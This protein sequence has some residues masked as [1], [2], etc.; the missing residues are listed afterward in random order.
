MTTT[1]TTFDPGTHARTSDPHTSHKAAR[2]AAGTAQAHCDTIA[3]K[4]EEHPLVGL[5]ASEIAEHTT[6]DKVQ[7]GR[8]ISDLI[9]QGRAHRQA[10]P[11]D[12]EFIRYNSAGRGETVIF[13]GAGAR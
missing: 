11:G 10:S 3:D 12:R 13:P 8:R 4:L 9:R 6:I 2:A 1:T 5:T 7:V